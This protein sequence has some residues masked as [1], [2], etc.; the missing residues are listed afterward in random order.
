MYNDAI[1][2]L[3]YIQSIVRDVPVD[4]HAFDSFG[5]LWGP[6]VQAK[7]VFGH[8]INGLERWLYLKT[9][10]IDCLLEFLGYGFMRVICKFTLCC[11]VSAAC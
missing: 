3:V 4:S 5:V 11:I 8:F 1:V 7:G 10:C 9:C 2:W 6:K